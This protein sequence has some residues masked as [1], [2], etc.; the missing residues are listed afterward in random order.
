MNTVIPDANP[1]SSWYVRFRSECARSQ[2]DH[3]LTNIILKT[4]TDT[5]AHNMRKKNFFWRLPLHY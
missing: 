1:G 2:G 3:Q 5:F 4:Y